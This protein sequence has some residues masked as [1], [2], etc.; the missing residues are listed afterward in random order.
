[1]ASLEGVCQAAGA[2]KGR[3]PRSA[4]RIE[5]PGSVYLDPSP[6]LAEGCQRVRVQRGAELLE[7]LAFSIC[8]TPSGSACQC[9]MCS[10]SMESVRPSILCSPG[11]LRRPTSDQRMANMDV[12]PIGYRG[13]SQRRAP[14][15]ARR[16]MSL[17]TL[18]AYA[19][20]AENPLSV[21]R[22]A[23][24]SLNG[25]TLLWAWAGERPVPCGKPRRSLKD[26][27]GLLALY[28]RPPLT[29]LSPMAVGGM[30][31]GGG[32]PSRSRKHAPHLGSYLAGCR[33]PGSRRHG[34]SRASLSKSVSR[35]ISAPYFAARRARR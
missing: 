30:S 31:E 3:P 18:S 33:S 17:P 29:I 35:S 25:P 7:D 11:R 22:R 9:A 19:G 24:R 32:A 1:M 23:Q 2:L 4:L 16:S 8:H 6:L 10:A 27:A 12:L 26:R 13:A 15:R 20:L 5:G 14:F 21:R 28:P 34:E